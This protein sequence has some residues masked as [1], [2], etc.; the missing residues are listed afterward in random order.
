MDENYNSI[1]ITTLAVAVGSIATECLPINV[2]VFG[3][4]VC[5]W[6]SLTTPNN[7]IQPQW[8][9]GGDL[10]WARN[11]CG[12]G[13]KSTQNLQPGSS[14]AAAAGNRFTKA[15]AYIRGIASPSGC[16]IQKT[17]KHSASGGF[18]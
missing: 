5:V 3:V 2:T 4:C 10:N 7:N 18:S 12:G 1:I 9:V 8:R 6:C 17:F 16:S 13:W 11:V 14:A 15:V